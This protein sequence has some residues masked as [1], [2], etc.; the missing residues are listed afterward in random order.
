MARPKLVE[1]N[2]SNTIIDE[3]SI[4][5]EARFARP[6]ALASYL[7]VSLSTVLRVLKEYED[8]KQPSIE[9]L[10]IYVTS[11]IRVI[12]IHKFVEYLKQRET[13]IL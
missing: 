3:E 4:M 1:P 6:K 11:T 12:D 10:Y 8:E 5:F 7:G 13:K 2:K 9:D